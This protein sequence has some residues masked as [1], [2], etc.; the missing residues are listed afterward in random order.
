MRIVRTTPPV[1]KALRIGISAKALI[2]GERSIRSSTRKGFSW[3]NHE[4]CFYCWKKRGGRRPHQFPWA[5]TNV[6]GR[7]GRSRKVNPQSMVHLDREEPVPKT[8]RGGPCSNSSPG[9]GAKKRARSVSAGFG[10]RRLIAGQQNRAE[11]LSLME[12][13]PPYCGRDRR[14]VLKSSPGDEGPER[15]PAQEAAA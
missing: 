15:L 12:L 8:G 6:P 2:W 10:V 11:G 14:A 3:G 13:D 7:V 4:W 5:R 9:S 1:L